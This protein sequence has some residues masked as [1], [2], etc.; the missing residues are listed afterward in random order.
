[1]HELAIAENIIDAVLKKQQA[2]HL[3][4]I[5]TVGLRIGNLTDVVTEALEFGFANAILD[6]PLAGSRLAIERVPIAGICRSCGSSVEVADF[7]FTCPNC[8][9]TDLNI[10][11]G[12]ELDIAWLEIDDSSV[13]GHA[14]EDACDNKE[15]T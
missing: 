10:T 8:S 9:S 3:G 7:R 12:L 2:D 4:R 11:S 13:S 5:I 1:M 15:N 14:A 6:S